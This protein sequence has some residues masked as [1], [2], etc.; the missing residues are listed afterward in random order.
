MLSLSPEF[1]IDALHQF[2]SEVLLGMTWVFCSVT[3]LVL[4]RMFGV[5]GLFGYISVAIIAANIQVLKAVQFSF[6]DFPVALGTV[7]FS[8]IFLATDII[9]ERFGPFLAQ[10]AIWMSFAAT[11]LIMGIMTFT[12]GF[13]P[14]FDETGYFSEAHYAI[15]DLFTP[16]PGLLVSSVSAYLISQHTDIFIFQ[17]IRKATNDRFLWLR[18]NISTL[19]SS[20]LDTVIFATLAWGVF[21]IQSIH[22]ERLLYTYI[23]GAYG[24]RI[25]ISILNTPIMYLSRYCLSS[26]GSLELSRI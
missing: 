10:R 5:F 14:A 26:E 23:F 22:F 9:T 1:I 15:Q 8:S 20:F 19:A 2:S 24:L 25:F 16:A 7:V 21:E 17:I 13:R 12:L 6:F 11:I 4:L 18:T 3:L